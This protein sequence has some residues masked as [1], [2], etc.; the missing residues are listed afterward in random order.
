M[1]RKESEIVYC[2]ECIRLNERLGCCMLFDKKTFIDSRY[3]PDRYDYCSKGIKKQ[4]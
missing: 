4:K 3:Y 2:S 1:N